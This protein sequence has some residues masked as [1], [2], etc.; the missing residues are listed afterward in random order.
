MRIV[1]GSVV[2]A[3]LVVVLS[4][5]R[6]AAA[7]DTLR[8]ALQQE[9]GTLNPVISTLAVEIDAYNLLFDGLFR[10]DEHGNLVPD[11]AT[12]VPT[13]QNGDIS[14]D[15]LTIIYHLVRNAK[16]HDG[17]PVTSDDVKFTYEAIMDPH[18]NVVTRI[19]YDHFARVDAPDPYTVVVHL[20][21]PFAP[22]VVMSFT[23]FSQGAIVPA[24]VLRGVSD[25]NHSAFGTNPVGSGP[26]RFVA[27]HHG[28]DMIFEANPAYH[29]KVPSIH[30]IVW[31]FTPSENTI[32][33]ELRSHDIDLVDKLGIAA[34]TQLGPIPGFLPAL[35]PSTLWE[36][37]TLNA[38]SG[39]LQ[40]VRVR[41]ALCEGFDIREIYAKVVHGIGSL[42]VGLQPPWS[43]WYD[44]TLRP[45]AHDPVQARKLLDQAG[46]HVGPDG[47]R[48]KDGKPLQITFTTVAGIIDREQTAV[49][50]Q[51]RWREIGVD[52][53]IKTFP[54]ATFFAPGQ[55]G[56]IFYGGKFDVALSAFI[57]RSLDPERISFDTSAMIPPEGQN[58]AFWRNARVDALEAQGV[59]V[60]DE[61]QRRR[62]YDEIQQIEAREVPYVIMRWWTS[63]AIHDVRLHGLRDAPVGS[64]YWN[65]SDWTFQ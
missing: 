27:W 65:V 48:T 24:H 62:I 11:L 46:W 10:N 63:I 47:I 2:L 59:R 9:P 32:I 35:A 53:Q 15:G 52:T 41:R 43:T 51:S 16:W 49:I 5:V 25:L 4:P 56:G 50:L 45:C 54:A 30:R 8:V 40:D 21:Q 29:R 34:Y 57:L 42:G 38:G 58:T 28:N 13:Q 22:A 60:Y 7:E 33:S 44:Q 55:A 3:F 39:P 1:V 31:H 37:L 61:S 18:N 19:P 17:Q 23:N 20:K 6:P 26:Y 12:R 36:H 64:L 14:R